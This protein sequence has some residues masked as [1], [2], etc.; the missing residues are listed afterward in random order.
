MNSK[1]NH[2]S[3]QYK[4]SNGNGAQTILDETNAT[5]AYAQVAGTIGLLQGANTDTGATGFDQIIINILSSTASI[6]NVQVIPLATNISGVQYDQTPV[7]R[8]RAYYS[9][10]INTVGGYYGENPGRLTLTTGVAVTTGDVTSATLYYTPYKGNTI[11][12]YTN[13][14]WALYVYSELSIASPA[15][16]N[17]AYDVF[18]S[19][20]TGS[21][22]TLVLV[23]WTNP[24][25]RATALV[26][27]D[28][29]YVLTGNT[30]R[31]Y[32]GSVLIDSSLQF[33]DSANF[34]YVWN[35]YNRIMRA[36]QYITTDTRW[37]YTTAAWRQANGNT[38]YQANL[39]IGLVEDSMRA[40]VFQNSTN[41]AALN[42]VAVGIGLSS[43]TVNSA[44]Q[45]GNNNSSMSV[46][47]PVTCEYNGAGYSIGY[48]N[49]VW[50]EWSDTGG[51][52]SWSGTD[53]GLTG[54]SSGMGITVNIPM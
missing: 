19:V 39:M 22:V 30:K 2:A 38:A 52:T 44:Q 10:L 31:R 34:R 20:E 11:W 48:N 54:I 15:V 42:A 28:G 37:N 49:I 46:F 18:A 43:T 7:N 17:T 13:G 51:T 6:S 41:G 50:L 36:A 32:L 47:T 45:F 24:T 16:I 29:V 5:G 14:R 9:Q 23:A 4:P 33:K 35:K 40:F 26:L 1:L 53:V 8:Q 27:Q 21:T 3:M 12:L 25:T